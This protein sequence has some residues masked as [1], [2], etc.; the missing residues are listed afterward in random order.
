[1]AQKKKVPKKMVARKPAAAKKPVVK[2]APAPRRWF[3]FFKTFSIITLFVVGAGV[4][5]LNPKLL[6]QLQANLMVQAPAPIEEG[7]TAS[8][9]DEAGILIAYEVGGENEK[10]LTDIFQT[11]FPN[12]PIRDVLYSSDEG[13]KMMT[14]WGV[15]EVPAL[16]FKKAAFDAEKLSEVVKDLFTLKGEYYSLNVALVNPSHQVRVNGA[17]SSE[18]GI[19]IGEKEAPITAYLYSDPRCQHC[20]VNEQNNRQSFAKLVSEGML[21]IAYLDLPQTPDSIFHSSALSCFYDQ[22]KDAE[23]YLELRTKIFDRANLTKAY[24]LRELQRLG[25]E[26]DSEC[27]EAQYRA[28]FRNRGTVADQEGVTGIPVLYIGKTG[29]D[30][31]IRITG[32]KDFSEYQTVLDKL[33][34]PQ[35]DQEVPANNG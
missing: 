26:Y 31:F 11:V 32:S 9:A 17:P 25:V 1:M 28:L 7:A 6:K 27:D 20:R 4:L 3:S 19:W 13:K 22:K 12:A 15:S 21:Q 23:K 10:K 34:G 2:A 14:D 8:S 5:T 33:L 30:Q 16:F 29:G 35:G 24:T 18:N